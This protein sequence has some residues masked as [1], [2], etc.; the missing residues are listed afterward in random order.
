MQV[1]SLVRNTHEGDSRKKGLDSFKHERQERLTGQVRNVKRT[2]TKCSPCAPAWDSGPG[3]AKTLWQWVGKVSSVGWVA[4]FLH[5]GR[6]PHLEDCM[7][8]IQ[9][10]L[11]FRERYNGLLKD[12]GPSHPQPV[13]RGFRKRPMWWGYIYTQKGKRSEH[14]NKCGEV[15]TT[16]ESK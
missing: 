4:I 3:K 11:C 8:A 13:F 5:H 14:P 7:L 10:C 15:L 6:F 2:T 16:R 1:L 9:E 12:D